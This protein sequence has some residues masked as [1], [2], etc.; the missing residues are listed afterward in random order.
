MDLQQS[1]IDAR[2]L[3]MQRAAL[4]TALGISV[5]GNVGLVLYNA[6]RAVEVVLQPVLQ[7][8]VTISSSYVSRD[9][10]E[11][12]TR[13]TAY[14]VLNRTPQSLD[15]WMNT[16]LKITDPAYY[17]AVK[18]KLLQ[19]VSVLRGNDVTQ[20]IEIQSIDVAPDRLNSEITGVLHV[21]EGQREVSRTPVHYHFDWT[22]RGL[23]LKL[24]GFGDVKDPSKQPQD[25]PTNAF[26]EK[27]GQ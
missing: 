2:K 7:R 25:Q 22:Y 4:I 10:L 23:S 3:Q 16:V 14:A 5:A 19:A 11:M 8:P 15:Y 17:G 6:T 18:A 9:Y 13:D 26:I 20:M 24:A 27:G 1:L 21:F 12:V